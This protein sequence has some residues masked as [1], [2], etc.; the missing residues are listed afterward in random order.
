EALRLLKRLGLHP[1]RTIRL[2]LFT[3]EENGTRGGLGY[4]DAHRAELDK[5]VLAM[6]SDAGV[7]PIQGYS[8]TG[9][10]KARDVIAQVTALLTP[11]GGTAI[12]DG[13]DGTDILP[14]VRAGNVPALSQAVDMHRYFFLHHTPADTVDKV[15]PADLARVTAAMASV[16]YVVADMPGTLDRMPPEPVHQQPAPIR[17]ETR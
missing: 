6:E 17:T 2:V 5:H 9:S 1:R 13:V 7:L 14:M 11:L 8:F 15:V 16:A 12:Q 3:N 4:R 10:G